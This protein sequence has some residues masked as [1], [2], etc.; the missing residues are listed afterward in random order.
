MQI[1]REEL[2]RRLETASQ[3]RLALRRI[4]LKWRELGARLLDQS[5]EAA[6]PE[7][8]DGRPPGGG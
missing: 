5:R 1:S 8:P 3:V 7:R 4:T 6:G 2:D